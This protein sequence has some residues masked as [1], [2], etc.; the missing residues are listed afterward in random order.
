[1]NIKRA[2]CA[3]LAL[4]T[5]RGA[6]SDVSL[7]FPIRK[8]PNCPTARLVSA[9]DNPTRGRRPVVVSSLPNLEACASLRIAWHARDVFRL[10]NQVR[11]PAPSGFFIVRDIRMVSTDVYTYVLNLPVPT[12]VHVVTCLL[13]QQRGTRRKSPRRIPP[14]F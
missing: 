2:P 8:T 13:Q 9:P 6:L 14:Q 12:S 5:K 4:T 11:S 1:M 7:V 10:L 3:W